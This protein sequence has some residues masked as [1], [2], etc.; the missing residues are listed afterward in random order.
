[1]IKVCLNFLKGD[2]PNTLLI[3]KK[4]KNPLNTTKN[5]VILIKKSQERNIL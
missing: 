5:L 1:M 3:K 4:K 2:N